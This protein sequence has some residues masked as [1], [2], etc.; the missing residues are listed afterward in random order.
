[1]YKYRAVLSVFN[2][3]EMMPLEFFYMIFK[4]LGA[5]KAKGTN[6]TTNCIATEHFSTLNM[7]QLFSVIC[8]TEE[9]IFRS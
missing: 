9:I 5:T 2:D 1:M 8:I 3:Y 6:K 7:F 4:M